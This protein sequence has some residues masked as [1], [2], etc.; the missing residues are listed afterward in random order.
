MILVVKLVIAVILAGDGGGMR[1]PW[2]V[3][4]CP[5]FE[6]RSQHAVRV[7]QDHVTRYDLIGNQDNITRREHSLLAYPNAA[8][9]MSVALF[10]AALHMDDCYIGLHS[11]HE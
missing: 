11:R 6:R 4:D 1:A 9:K 7:A 3:N 2:F 5:N 10:V 8:P